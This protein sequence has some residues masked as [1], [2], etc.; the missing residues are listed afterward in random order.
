MNSRMRSACL[1]P[2]RSDFSSIFICV[3]GGDEMAILRSG[4]HGRSKERRREE[5][6]E[7]AA[8]IDVVD[9]E[10]TMTGTASRG[11][12]NGLTLNFP[13][14]LQRILYQMELIARRCLSKF[15][16]VFIMLMTRR[17]L[18]AS[19]VRVWHVAAAIV[20][21]LKSAS[22]PLPFTNSYPRQYA[23]LTLTGATA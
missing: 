18:N 3:S 6:N 23:A 17:A 15:K 10:D 11:Q 14:L 9:S 5:G 13:P 1:A 4:E 7:S 16:F 12:T 19:V 21:F 20:I 22:G 2:L 8:A